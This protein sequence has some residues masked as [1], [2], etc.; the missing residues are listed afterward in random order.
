MKKFLAIF[1]VLAAL[2][3]GGLWFQANFQQFSDYWRARDYQ[4]S[5]QIAEIVAKIKLTDSAKTVF[6]ATAP[7][8]LASKEF[9]QNCSNLLEKSSILGCYKNGSTAT[10]K[11]F[12]YDVQNT[13][14][15]G[16]KEVTSAHEL[17][18]AVWARLSASER[19]RLGELLQAE[20][21]RVKTD[22]LA[23]TMASYAISEP[24]E[25]NNE[26]HSILGTEIS[27]LSGEL[28]QYYAKIFENRGEI[29]ALNQK[30]QAKFEQLAVQAESLDAELRTLEAEI[31]QMSA[32]YKT[33]IEALNDDIATFN[34]NAEKGF[35][36]SQSYF[37]ADRNR[38]VARRDSLEN[39]RNQINAKVDTHNQKAAQLTQIAQQIQRLY[40]SLNSQLEEVQNE[41]SL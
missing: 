36:S 18:H 22:K 8:I 30:Y 40:D 4:P 9:N 6:Y 1:L 27:Q 21:A 38:L 35:Y 7:Q 11:I 16:V 34:L 23:K 29:V 37:Y 20:Y 26:L 33:E 32:E 10:D 28:E 12:I 31:I 14:L 41:S 24:G 2:I 13:E 25:E 39:Y 3:G 19:E 17:L 5:A 15:D